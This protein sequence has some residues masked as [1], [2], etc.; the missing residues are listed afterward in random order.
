[1][2]PPRERV[3][4][5]T[6][7]L[8]TVS[9]LAVFAAVL[10]VV[11][12]AVLPHASDAVL[13]IIPHLNALISG[14]AIIVI[15]MGWRWARHENLQKH[16]LAM[17]AGVVLFA[18][19]LLLY[20]YKV[21][22]EGPTEFSGTGLLRTAYLGV[23]AVHILLAIVCIPLLYYV[24][25]LALTRPLEE[26]PLTNHPRIGRVAASLWLI[27]FALGIVVYAMLYVF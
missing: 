15:S 16:R 4:E 20:L 10:G 13:E 18:T 11:P 14:T 27:S 19:F 5:L 17:L 3:P 6:I 9:L 25:L 21:S 22:L 7:L 1:M 8:T 23:L 2:Q 26:I 24:L 12:Q